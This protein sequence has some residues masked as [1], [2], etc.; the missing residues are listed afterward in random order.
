MTMGATPGAPTP[1]ALPNYGPPLAVPLAQ[2]NAV[3]GN[4][5]NLP[6]GFLVATTCTQFN[7]V[8]TEFNTA[9]NQFTAQ[10]TQYSTALQTL[11]GVVPPT[12]AGI[13]NASLQV[14]VLQGQQTNLV[15]RHTA[16]LSGLQKRLD[17]VSNDLARVRG[18]FMFGM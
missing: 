7:A 9:Q 18:A 5:L 11:G 17:L 13:L 3:S 15:A 10:M 14:Q 12:I 4:A 1:I 2:C 8:I 16:N 6:V